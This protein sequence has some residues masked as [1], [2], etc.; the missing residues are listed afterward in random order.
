LTI[1]QLATWLNITERPVRR[2]VTERRVPFHKVGNRVR[3]VPAEVA[4]WLD[5][6]R[7]RPVDATAAGRLGSRVRR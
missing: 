7:T 4:A 5:A 3:F 2:L 1:S 6:N